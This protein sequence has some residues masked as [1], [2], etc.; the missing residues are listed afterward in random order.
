MTDHGRHHRFT[1][2]ANLKSFTPPVNFKKKQIRLKPFP[3]RNP[4]YYMRLYTQ[5]T[6][7]GN[8]R[9]WLAVT[10]VLA[11]TICA[12]I[13]FLPANPET[14]SHR[15]LPELINTVKKGGTFN[16]DP[17][18]SIWGTDED[19]PA[20]NDGYHKV[21]EFKVWRNRFNKKFTFFVKQ[22]EYKTLRIILAKPKKTGPWEVIQ[23]IDLD[24]TSQITLAV[25]KY[26]FD[27]Q[28]VWI[29]IIGLRSKTVTFRE[30]RLA[31]AMVQDL[32]GLYLLKK[33]FN[34]LLSDHIQFETLQDPTSKYWEKYR[35]A[36]YPKSYSDLHE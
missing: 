30:P 11:T 16:F 6:S 34:E 35:E 33:Y 8:A 5:S 4:A 26:W 9:H 31:H 32:K 13:Y 28:T 21:G 22:D 19:Q 10:V 27:R 24:S 2:P 7:H 18:R 1:P 3:F 20:P 15:R 17:S 12:S 29:K 25:G 14:A 36:N 23:R